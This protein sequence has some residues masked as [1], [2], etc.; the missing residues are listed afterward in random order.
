MI[1][2]IICISRFLLD[3]F[4]YVPRFAIEM[5]VRL[6]QNRHKYIK[7]TSGHWRFDP[8][9]EW[10][11]RITDETMELRT[12]MNIEADHL[13][14]WER[15]NKARLSEAVDVANFAMMAAYADKTD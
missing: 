9:R 15:T 13:P 2:K 7:C 5:R 11:I 1:E 3:A 10:L 14:A 8:A 12:A 6:W 4:W